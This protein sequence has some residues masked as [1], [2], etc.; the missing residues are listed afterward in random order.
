MVGRRHSRSARIPKQDKFNDD[1]VVVLL[2]GL[3]GTFKS[4][5]LRCPSKFA[6]RC[7]KA[8]WLRTEFVGCKH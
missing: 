6:H 8:E 3:G 7:V 2:D 1:Y 4:R 5:H